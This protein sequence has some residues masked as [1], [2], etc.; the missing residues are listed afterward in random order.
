L[1]DSLLQEKTCFESELC[2]SSGHD[3]S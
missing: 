2:S 1:L 3:D